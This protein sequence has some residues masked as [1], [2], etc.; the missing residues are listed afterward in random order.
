M[1]GK[2]L[3]RKLRGHGRG[4]EEDGLSFLQ[5]HLAGDAAGDDVA[6]G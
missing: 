5:S 1:V 2:R 3:A 6:G 4:V